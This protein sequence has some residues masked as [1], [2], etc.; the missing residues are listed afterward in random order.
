MSYY[1][2]VLNKID[3]FIDEKDYNKAYSLLKEEL[4]MEYIPKDFEELFNQ[5]LNNINSFIDKPNKSLSEDEIN[6]YLFSDPQKQLI[7]VSSLSKRNLR[8]FIYLINSYLISDGFI[9]AKVLLIDELIKQEISETIKYSND[10]VDYEFIPKYLLTPTETDGFIEA[11]RLLTEFY[12]KEPSKLKLAQDLLYKE[13]ILM[14]P[15]NPEKQ[16]GELLFNKV[17]DY[18]TQAFN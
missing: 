18:I 5:R 17:K 2:E 9:N 11:N 6:M 1:D 15:I 4:S 14:L 10:G 7:A 3:K 16:E 13:V 12:M 8:D